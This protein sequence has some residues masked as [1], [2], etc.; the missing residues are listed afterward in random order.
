MERILALLLALTMLF[1]L[2]ACGGDEVGTL[3]GENTN[4]TEGK[5]DSINDTQ[6]TIEDTTGNTAGGENT[7][8]GTNTSATIPSDIQP[9]TSEDTENKE[10]TTE[11]N[12]TSGAQTTQPEHTHDYRKV[13][14]VEATC[15]EKGYS[16]YIC[17]CGVNYLGDHTEELGHSWLDA[18]CTTAKTCSNCQISEGSA[19]GH[20]WKD[21]SCA[22]PKKCTNCGIIEGMALP[23]DMSE[24]T[25][26]SVPTCKICGYKDGDPADHKFKRSPSD[27]TKDVCTECGEVWNSGYD[28][29][30]W[31]T[32]CTTPSKCIYCD[33]NDGKI[34]GHRFKNGK[35]TV[36]NA[37]E[38]E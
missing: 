10:T 19:L 29:D 17:N 33:A 11:N 15:T 37:K 2:T 7:Q 27:C 3:T 24:A 38:T 31:F 36:C 34:P 4:T 28:H 21:A 35:C 9:S 26:S 12:G 5:N 23:H 22:S 30:F 1:C 32:S 6:D 14:V 18:T 20:N 25:C 13:S 16:L 8:M